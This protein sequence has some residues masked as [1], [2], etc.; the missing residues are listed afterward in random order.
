MF[1]VVS[2]SVIKDS[3]WIGSFVT[4]GMWSFV[5]GRFDEVSCR[6]SNEDVIVVVSCLDVRGDDAALV[7]VAVD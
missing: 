3:V 5:D 6:D 4:K 7:V 1:F 2:R